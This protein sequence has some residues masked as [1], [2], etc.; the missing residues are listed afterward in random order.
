MAL[1]IGG[2]GGIV[3][4]IGVVVLM[5]DAAAAVYQPA[6]PDPDGAG[7]PAPDR[8]SVAAGSQNLSDPVYR[9]HKPDGITCRSFGHNGFQ[10]VLRVETEHILAG[11]VD[12]SARSAA[13]A[14]SASTMA[15]DKILL[16]RGHGIIPTTSLSA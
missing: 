2:F 16:N 3:P 13:S 11:P 6:G 14:G 7:P 12:G 8:I 9:G 4:L 15:A 10:P 5:L 1:R